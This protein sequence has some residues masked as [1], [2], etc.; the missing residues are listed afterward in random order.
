MDVLK[1]HPDLTP[2]FLKV[3]SD[4]LKAAQLRISE[5]ERALADKVRDFSSR[6]S[7]LGKLRWDG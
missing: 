1:E 3:L 7:R 5:L 6:R 4:A 2:D